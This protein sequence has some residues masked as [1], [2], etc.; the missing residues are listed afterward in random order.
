LNRRAARPD[1]SGRSLRIL[2]IAQAV[3]I[4]TARWLNQLQD[5]GWDLHVFDMLGSFPHAE[6][7]GVTEYSLLLPRRV[8]TKARPV[9]YGPDF[10][11]RRGWDPFPISLV[12]FFIRRIFRD[13]VA[14][15]TRLIRRL[16]PD[17]I[18]SFELQTESYHVLD[19]VRQLGGCL[20]A[21]WIVSTWGSD[22]FFF[23]R[24]P[25]HVDKIKAVL[26][27]CDYLIPDCQRDAALAREYGFEGGIPLIL[28]G[29]GAY[30]VH[31]MRAAGPRESTSSRSTI[32]VKGYEGWAGRAL[33]ALNALRLC[34][35]VLGGYDVLVYSASPATIAA[36]EQLR[37][38]TGMRI[39]IQPRC[40]HQ[41]IV[42]L[43]GR[44][45]LAIA[46]NKTDGIPN[47]MLEAMTMGAFPI[48]SGTESTSE[49]ITDGENGLLV[50]ADDPNQIAAAIRRGLDDDALVDKAA[51]TNLELVLT[52]LDAAVVRP[53]I[54]RMYED[55]A[56]RGS[57]A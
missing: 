39:R 50:D 12:G 38:S 37:K 11:L 53:R 30:P 49:W 7:G 34:A 57:A 35:D 3:S 51:A 6:L 44:S 14:R 16:N 22:I 1:A 42:R 4:H 13:R 20:P 27:E 21:P 8:A 47:A 36:V 40:A 28:P 32:L 29:A 26:R 17:V 46:V 2:F 55:I 48:Q 56:S 33:S 41:E 52:R 18:H 25:E 23:Q 43:F 45:R 24:F 5:L 10:F 19:V 15:L 54:I 9:S 31:E